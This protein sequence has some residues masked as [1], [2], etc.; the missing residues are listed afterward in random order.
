MDARRSWLTPACCPC[1]RC[2]AASTPKRGPV[3]DRPGSPPLEKRFKPGGVLAGSG[4]PEVSPWP[5]LR[6]LQPDSG[7]DSPP[8]IRVPRTG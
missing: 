6:P 2:A 4:S 3:A 1:S 5:P 7:R 8:L